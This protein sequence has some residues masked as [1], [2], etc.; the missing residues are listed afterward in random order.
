MDFM[1]YKTFLFI[2]MLFMSGVFEIKNLKKYKKWK[3]KNQPSASQNFYLIISIHQSLFSAFGKT[4]KKL[5]WKNSKLI[6]I[7][8]F[9]FFVFLNW[10]FDNFDFM[11]KRGEMKK[12]WI[13][14]MKI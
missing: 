5:V 12:M 4:K 9:S 8:F 1:L 13:K 7:H 10:L 6:L 14:T 3:H 11:V 2:K